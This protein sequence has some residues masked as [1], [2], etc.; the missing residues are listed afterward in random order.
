MPED[1]TPAVPGVVA[2]VTPPAPAG[3]PAAN[4][5]FAQMRTELAALKAEKDA[6]AAEKTALERR[7][8]DEKTRLAAELADAQKLA[9][10]LAPAKDALGRFQAQ[11]EQAC[12]TEL[13]SIPEEKRAAIEAVV[14]QIPLEGRLTAIQSMR[15]AIGVAPLAAGYV[16]QPSASPAAGLPG[17]PE[18]A[19]PLGIAEIGK[20]SWSDALKGHG[21]MS[22]AM[23]SAPDIKSMVADAVK[24]AMAGR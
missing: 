10:E 3:D 9:Q 2:P 5:A 14:N 6:L 7:D 21:N 22:P 23:Q 16:T 8:M 18:A 20:L 1:P 4:A 24:E 13:A 11:I 19:K 17:G 12:A 15:S